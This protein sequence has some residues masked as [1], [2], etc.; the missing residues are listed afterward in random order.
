MIYAFGDFEL[1]ERRFELRCA[2]SRVRVQPK[3]LDLIFL[4]VRARDRVVLKREMLDAIWADVTVSEASISRI[5]L[6][7]RKAI[8]DDLQQAIV[9]VRGRGFRFA[10]SVV[11]K[12]TAPL[13]TAAEPRTHPAVDPTFVG[14]EV[15]LAAMT[16]RL[17]DAIAGRGGLVLLS[18]E[19]G[20][21]KT[22]TG[23]EIARRANARG[24][25]VLTAHA[26]ET[27]EAPPF[28]LWGELLRA[29]T[30]DRNDA[31]TV[32]FLARAAPVLAGSRVESSA[33]QFALF[34][35]VTRYFADAS[36]AR[37]IVIVLDD[38]HWADEPSLQLLE[39]FA[40]DVRKHA[41]LLVGTYRDSALQGDSRARA[42]GGLIAQ[43]NS[44]SL[45]LRGLS[46]EE[47]AAMVELGT[48]A[49]PSEAF[50]K[51]IFERSGGNPLYI[52]QLLKTDWA[53]RA[54]TAAAHEM[55]STMDLQQGLIET[56][57]R[58]LDSMSE[59]GRAILTLAAVL[60]REFQL[61]KLGVVSGLSPDVLLDRL[62]EAVRANVLFQA[63]DGQHR[64][65][66]AL[67]RDVL[68]KKLSSVERAAKH[69]AVGEGLLAHYADAIDAHATELADH[70][71][72][73]LPGA[74]PERAIDLAM[75]AAEQE[76]ALGRHREAAKHWLQAA[77]ALGLLPRE[78][79]RRVV[80]QLGLARARLA[81]GRTSEAR[82]SFL[83]AAILART[84]ALPEELAEAALAYAAVAGDAVEQRRGLLDQ[85]L[86]ALGDA[87]DAK[88][89]RLRARI[90][91][92][93][94]EKGP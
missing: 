89:W 72:R 63:K 71:A 51:A 44:L 36:R 47:V 46:F 41:L 38:L 2:G 21:G 76:T 74:D 80:V 90:E 34:D 40:R 88:A 39:F 10:L 6:E 19:A 13:P 5:I 25:H 16:A 24:A 49:A 77:Q 84:F 83:D 67:V 93:L 57:C 15:C 75:R 35:A 31:S 9:T 27:P 17:D 8:G 65:A 54:L 43:T 52:E 94:A 56:I 60:G 33:A 22:R 29:Y 64:F 58:Q 14:R 7:A 23:E 59:P 68:Y 48:G 78:D 3:V 50:V 69:R 28:W 18:G 86:A 37:A 30:R 20:I 91:I 82:E 70:F 62:D 79:A 32:E 73:A 53:E 1:D 11:E 92:A 45:P 81:A 4:L 42:F 66:H 85:A 55:V 87:T 12:E 61:T 26:H